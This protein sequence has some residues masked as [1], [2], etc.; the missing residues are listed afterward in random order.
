[1]GRGSVHYFCFEDRDY[2]LRH[3]RRGGKMAGLLG[4]RYL[5]QGLERTRAWR[6][7]R[8]LA[9]MVEM[10][11]PVP[12]PCAAHV[13]RHGILYRADLIT[14]RIPHCSSLAERL[15]TGAL[16]E[17]TWREIGR[18]IARFHKQGIWHADLNAHNVLLGVRGQPA[19]V[20]F[21]RSRLRRPR[22]HWREANLARLRRSLRKLRR[23]DP[24]LQFHDRDFAWLREGYEQEDPGGY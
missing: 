4:D 5:W 24:Q 1:M 8:M 11:L 9:C 17:N 3:Y 10:R 16:P 6:E 15:R 18:V 20:D 14:A 2:V 7:W 21:D 19:L 23:L 12:T 22:R 13:V